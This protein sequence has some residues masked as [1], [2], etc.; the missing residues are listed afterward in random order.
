MTILKR[1]FGDCLGEQVSQYQVDSVYK[2][3]VSIRLSSMKAK[4]LSTRSLQNC[5]KICWQPYWQC[6]CMVASLMMIAQSIWWRCLHSTLSPLSLSLLS[7]LSSSLVLTLSHKCHNISIKQI[8]LSLMDTWCL[9]STIT[10]YLTL[11]QEAGGVKNC[12]GANNNIPK[13]PHIYWRPGAGPG[14]A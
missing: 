6:R 3:P 4:A 9:L 11:A 8:L 14:Y 10:W 12:L 5:A 2:C 1:P 13:T 7:I